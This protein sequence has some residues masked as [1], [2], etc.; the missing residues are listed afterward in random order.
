MV[1]Y[2][3][4]GRTCTVSV[5]TIGQ[6]SHGHEKSWKTMENEKIKSRPGKVMEND[7]LAKKLWKRHG[8][9]IF[10]KCWEKFFGK[11]SISDF[12]LQALTPTLSVLYKYYISFEKNVLITYTF[13]TQ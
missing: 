3:I 5:R 13:D 7:N 2:Y 9:L 6:G 10:H 4:K 12:L 1:V 11:L 8:I